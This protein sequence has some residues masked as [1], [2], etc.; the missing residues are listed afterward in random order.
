MSSGPFWQSQIGVTRAQAFPEIVQL[1]LLVVA[2]GLQQ[3]SKSPGVTNEYKFLEVW[4]VTVVAGYLFR[5]VMWIDALPTSC[6][7]VQQ[8][9]YRDVQNWDWS[10]VCGKLRYYIDDTK[11]KTFQIVGRYDIANFFNYSSEY[12]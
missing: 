10:L 4:L 6:G 11:W 2:Q 9:S 12:E 8:S 5:H 7:P 3:E 1:L